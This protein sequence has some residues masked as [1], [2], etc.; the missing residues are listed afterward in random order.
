ML[1]VAPATAQSIRNVL[2]QVLELT[3]EVGAKLVEH[4]RPGTVPLVI[5]DLRQRHPVQPGLGRD[6]LN[7]DATPFSELALLDLLGE[8]EPD[9]VM[10]FELER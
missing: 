4:V 9:H 5:Q 1:L 8:L 2:G 6:L 3:A 10:T 7:G